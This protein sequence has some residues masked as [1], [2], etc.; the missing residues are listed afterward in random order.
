MRKCHLHVKIHKIPLHNALH[1]QSITKEI[2][3]Y[4]VDKWPEA[5]QEGNHTECTPLH[6][7]CEH[8]KLVSNESSDDIELKNVVILLE[9]TLVE[10]NSGCFSKKLIHLPST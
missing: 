6:L 3:Q 7:L 10:T 1:N 4:L 8:G 5:L 9:L 2:I